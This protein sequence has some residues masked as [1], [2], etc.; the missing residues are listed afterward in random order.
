MEGLPS[1][2]PDFYVAAGRPETGKI[3]ET[4]LGE[5]KGL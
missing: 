4:L 1:T 3:A 2:T 5:R